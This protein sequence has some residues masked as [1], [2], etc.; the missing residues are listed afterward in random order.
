MR[1]CHFWG[2]NTFVICLVLGVHS[3]IVIFGDKEKAISFS[4]FFIIHFKMPHLYMSKNGLDKAATGITGLDEVTRGGLPAGRPTLLCGGAGCGKTVFSMEF[5]INGIREFDEPGVFFTLEESRDKLTENFASMEVN[6]K[7]HITN[8]ML[9]VDNLILDAEETAEMGDFN[10]E[11]LFLRLEH[12]I[13]QVGARRLVIDTIEAL[14]GLLHNKA[15]LRSEIRRLF[16]WLSDKDITTIITGEKSD[17]NLTRNGM[18]EFVSDCV[19][20]LDHRVVDQVSKRRLRIVKYRG[21]DHSSDEVPFSITKDGVSVLPITSLSLDHPVST[22]RLSSGAPDLDTLLDK[23]GFFEGTSI[24]VSGT[25]GTGKSSLGALFAARSCRDG[26]KGIYFSFEESPS[27]I[28][29]NMNSIGVPLEE[30]ADQDILVMHS[31]RTSS[32]GLEEH[33]LYFL[34]VIRKENPDFIVMDP[35]SNFFTVGNQS[36]VKAMLTRMVDYLKRSL[37]TGFFISLSDPDHNEEQTST[38]IS[39]L[40]DTWVVLKDHNHANEKRR[41]LYIIKARGMSHSRSLMEMHIT[42]KGISLS[43]PGFDI[44]GHS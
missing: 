14:F 7:E 23:D 18:E 4:T 5:I 43:E 6:M 11:P 15:I 34:R 25:A 9:F 17:D 35:I 39:S 20:L 38:G 44:D 12:A 22:K 27:Q 19:I 31:G 37:I 2:C 40:M 42:N 30:Y 3:W 24:L 16:N 10:L 28:I 26:N 29:R 13:Q 32:Q 1:N 8:K 41:L 36:E 21:S 33:L